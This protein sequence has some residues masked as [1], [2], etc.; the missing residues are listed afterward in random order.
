MPLKLRDFEVGSVATLNRW[1]DYIETQLKG[2]NAQLAYTNQL[3]NSG[4]GGGGVTPSSVEAGFTTLM[5]ALSDTTGPE[6]T[7][8]LVVVSASWVGPDS[9]ITATL[10]GSTTDHP[11]PEDGAIEGIVLSI[12][13]IIPGTS[14]EI[15][16]YAPQGSR[17]EYSVAYIGT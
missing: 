14:F 17:G 8:T 2:T 6:D 4:S 3:A 16:G 15:V 9:S 12:G 7:S 1:A 11:D 5:F 10:C 13:D